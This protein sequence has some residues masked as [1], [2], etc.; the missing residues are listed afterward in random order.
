MYSSAR[1]LLLRAA[2]ICS[3]NAANP[4]QRGDVYN[5]STL[6]PTHTFGQ[7][8][9]IIEGAHYVQI[10][11]SRD[12]YIIDPKKPCAAAATAALRVLSYSQ[13]RIQYIV[14]SE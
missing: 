7:F 1:E 4:S 13:S 2:Y 5:M 14:E 9:V 8:I 6:A 12:I 3:S 10:V 11:A